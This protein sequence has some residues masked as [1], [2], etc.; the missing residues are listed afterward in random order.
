MN[1]C[2]RK[3][4]SALEILNDHDILNPQ[5]RLKMTDSLLMYEHN[6]TS[7]QSIYELTQKITLDEPQ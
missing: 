3:R 2:I 6:Y 5:W 4:S 7:E 1:K